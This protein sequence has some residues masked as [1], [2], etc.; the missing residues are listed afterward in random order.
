M[1]SGGAASSNHPSFTEASTSYSAQLK[2]AVGRAY[3][4]VATQQRT[5]EHGAHEAGYVERGL[6][7]QHTSL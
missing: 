2:Q 1:I 5:F 3:S 7:V 4:C 6:N